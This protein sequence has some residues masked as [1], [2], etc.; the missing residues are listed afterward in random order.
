MIKIVHTF[1][2]G[3]TSDSVY[4]KKVKV[5]GNENFYKMYIRFIEGRMKG[6]ELNEHERNYNPGLH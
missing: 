4:S 3:T 5:E 1:A 6:G 2:D